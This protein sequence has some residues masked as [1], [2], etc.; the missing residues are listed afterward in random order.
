MA[1]C[2]V[3]FMWPKAQYG[4]ST[5]SATLACKA[6]AV[7]RNSR[8]RKGFRSRILVFRPNYEYSTFPLL[9]AGSKNPQ[10]TPELLINRFN[11]NS[12][13][14]LCVSGSWYPAGALG[15]NSG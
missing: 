15:C 13:L 12:E 6:E 8:I 14:T 2:P 10:L 1:A 3:G 4:S 7:A 5:N 11:V 9:F